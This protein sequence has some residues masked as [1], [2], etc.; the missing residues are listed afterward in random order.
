MKKKWIL[1]YTTMPCCMYMPISKNE[2]KVHHWI[3]YVKLES[4]RHLHF[5]EV[6]EVNTDSFVLKNAGLILFSEILEVARKKLR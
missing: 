6:V 4:I 1:D 3:M 5:D 2:V